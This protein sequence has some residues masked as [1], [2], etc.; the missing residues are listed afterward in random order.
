MMPLH[1]LCIPG[2][3]K[4]K[5]LV[6][7][8]AGGYRVAM[9]TKALGVIATLVALL[10]LA[11]ALSTPRPTSAQ[12]PPGILDHADAKPAVFTDEQPTFTQQ[13]R[14]GRQN[15]W[16][17][18]LAADPNSDYVYMAA[19]VLG[20]D[21]EGPEPVRTKPSTRVCAGCPIW[22]MAVWVS[23]DGG[24][25]WSEPIF[26]CGGGCRGVKR[27]QADPTLAVDEKGRVYFAF[28][29]KFSGALLQRS[30]DHGTT[31][32]RGKPDGGAH[33]H[34]PIVV[35][36]TTPTLDKPW[37]LVEPSGENIYIAFNNGSQ[38][39]LGRP[40]VAVSNNGGITF[41]PAMANSVDTDPRNWLVSNGVIAP[42]G[43]VY[44]V[45]SASTN[46]AFAGAIYLVASHDR[47]GT[48]RTQKLVASASPNE[49]DNDSSIPEAAIIAGRDGTLML[50]YVTASEDGKSKRLYTATSHDGTTWS[51]PTILNAESDSSFPW[52][53]SGPDAG[54]FRVVWA[55][56]RVGGAH[57][58][59][60]WYSHTRDG[61]ASWS[62]PVRLST[63]DGGAPWM[64]ESGYR[65]FYGDYMGLA[66]NRAGE[67]LVVWGEG[68]GYQKRGG[69][70]F[71]RSK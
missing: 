11:L 62:T 35:Q 64:S 3:S 52:I 13:V 1:A 17:P 28:M 9:R 41:N 29:D 14:M 56:N 59:N 63:L 19:M 18:T 60:T 27:W 36:S 46:P 34:R 30:T 26:P 50:A 22:V 37:L 40:Y 42:D 20:Q 70:W 38:S 32:T 61:G 58:W 51:A 57:P 10:V 67:S 21:A 12:G 48:W 25:T 23:D 15:I 53:A 44:F 69:I 66:V 5:R 31:W 68:R 54:D 8:H 65:A 2:W 6:R 45:E 24:H 39:T 33:F 43:S 55:D 47:G 71:S 49:A 16:E 7:R 4:S